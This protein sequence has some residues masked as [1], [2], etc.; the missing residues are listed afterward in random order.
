MKVT[1]V[2]Q[3]SPNT[4]KHIEEATKLSYKEMTTLCP[5]QIRALMIQRGVIKPQKQDM[6]KFNI[7]AVFNKI[8]EVGGN[9]EKSF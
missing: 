3:L 9:Y 7:R 2:Y 4:I 6:Q 8:K 1:P 5:H